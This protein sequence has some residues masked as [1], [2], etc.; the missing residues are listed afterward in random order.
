MK[1]SGGPGGPDDTLAV[2]TPLVFHAGLGWERITSPQASA[3]AACLNVTA[4]IHLLHPEFLLRDL[5][6]QAE[7][8]I[9]ALEAGAASVTV[10]N[11]RHRVDRTSLYPTPKE[12]GRD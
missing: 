10:I 12:A 11:D 8:A 4:R 2:F 9:R 7:Q 1:L 5:D 6:A 3:R